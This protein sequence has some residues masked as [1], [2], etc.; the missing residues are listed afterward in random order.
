MLPL[1]GKRTVKAGGLSSEVGF[2]MN[3]YKSFFKKW[4]Y[5]TGGLSSE[6]AFFLQVRL[7]YVFLRVKGSLRKGLSSKNKLKWSLISFS[8]L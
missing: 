2:N 6:V 1:L 4:S 8:Q 3:S 5:K 7:Y